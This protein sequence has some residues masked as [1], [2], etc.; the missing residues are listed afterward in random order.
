MFLGFPGLPGPCTWLKPCRRFAGWLPGAEAKNGTIDLVYFDIYTFLCP[1]NAAEALEAQLKHAKTRPQSLR[2]LALH[3]AGRHPE[4]SRTWG[5]GRHQP[6]LKRHRSFSAT[7]LKVYH[8]SLTSF[9]CRR[10]QDLVFQ[11][12]AVLWHTCSRNV[13]WGNIDCGGYW[14]REILMLLGSIFCPSESSL[15][16]KRPWCFQAIFTK[17][18]V[19]CFT[20]EKCFFFFPVLRYCAWN[21]WLFIFSR[22]ELFEDHVSGSDLSHCSLL[23]NLLTIFL[24][25]AHKVLWP[26]S[27]KLLQDFCI[28]WPLMNHQFLLI[29]GCSNILSTAESASDSTSM[30]IT[31]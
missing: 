22:F 21:S 24:T 23:C 9:V 14:R 1:E 5:K 30:P 16:V 28:L 3:S 26:C 10:F 18:T 11:A 8:D 20:A 31:I 29:S 6:R 7:Q 4:S 12:L 27:P 25:T 19:V 13:L 15:K 17:E 2:L